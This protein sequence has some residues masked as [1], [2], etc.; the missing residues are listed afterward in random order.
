MLGFSCRRAFRRNSIGLLTRRSQKRN[1]IGVL[2]GIRSARD[3][4]RVLVIG[5]FFT[6]FL[7][8]CTIS[9]HVNPTALA[10]GSEI[11]IIDN[12]AVR[13]GFL[14]ELQVALRDNGY[15]YRMLAASASPQDCPIALTYVARWSWDL[16]IYMSYAKLQVFENGR[17]AGDALYDSTKGGGNLSKF[18]DAEP[19][20]RELVDQLFPKQ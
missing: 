2:V 3:A 20:I 11:C 16:T 19:K 13:E 12:P 7:F 10:P 9:Q 17:P 15:V 6:V 8:G 18:I 4:I 1:S 14:S 5:A